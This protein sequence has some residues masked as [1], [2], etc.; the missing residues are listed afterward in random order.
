[1]K[2][3]FWKKLL[4]FMSCIVATLGLMCFVSCAADAGSDSDDNNTDKLV[5]DFNGGTMHGH[6]TVEFTMEDITPHV[7]KAIDEAFKCLGLDTAYIKKEGFYLH[8]W[9]LKKNGETCVTN[10]PTFGTLYAKW[11]T[12]P[13]PKDEDVPLTLTLDFN[14]GIPNTLKN[15]E[16]WRSKLLFSEVLFIHLGGGLPKL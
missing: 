15:L 7:G 6:K 9:T 16:G 10:L 3:N 12:D 8:G 14:G 13:L 5:L 4:T 1:M 11:G 2:G